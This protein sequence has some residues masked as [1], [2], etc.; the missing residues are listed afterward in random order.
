VPGAYRL[1]DALARFAG[2]PADD[3]DRMLLF[4]PHLYER[5]EQAVVRERLRPGDVF[6]DLGAHRGLYSRLAAG[7]VGPTGRVI[8][9][10]AH[11]E[12]AAGLSRGGGRPART[13]GGGRPARNIE[14]VCAAVSD[15]DGFA[16]LGDAEPT[17]GGGRSLL[18]PG[19]RVVP[20]RTVPGLLADLGVDRVDGAKLD[21]EG[22]EFRALS[23]WLP[24]GPRPRWLLVEHHP[25]LREAAGGDT[26]DLLRAHGYRVRRISRTN[27]LAC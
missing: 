13:R 11:P 9:V 1:A 27:H 2:G 19:D 16:T 24:V 17:N 18:K 26:L 6:L 5:R 15:Q 14:V 23:A 8:A 21:V 10:E 20:T 12:T 25:A 7:V 4:A 22:L 3:V